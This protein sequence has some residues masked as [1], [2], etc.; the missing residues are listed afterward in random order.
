MMPDLAVQTTS[1]QPLPQRVVKVLAEE[2]YRPKLVDEAEAPLHV[3]FKVE[4]RLFLV[5][6]E[7][8]DG[9]FV[10]VCAGVLLETTCKDELAHLRAA[11]A[12]QSATKYVRIHV[13]EDLEF[14]EFQVEPVLPEGRFTPEILAAAIGAI[15]AAWAAYF[16]RVTPEK[17]RA[18]A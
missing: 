7:E 10:Q 15:Q 12:V 18:V 2:G 9:C 14:V 4:G 17:P 8:T 11:R 6:F 3:S 5:H 16:Q 1:G 13:A